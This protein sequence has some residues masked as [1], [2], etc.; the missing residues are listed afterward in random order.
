[1]VAKSYEGQ[2]LPLQ[3]LIGEGNVGLIKAAKRFDGTRG[4]KFISYAVWWIR[5]AIL[6]ALAE[7]ARVVRLPLNRINAIIQIS[8]ATEVL[9]KKLGREPSMPELAKKMEMSES[10]LANL[11]KAALREQSLD[12]PV[13]DESNDNLVDFLISDQ[14]VAPDAMLLQKSLQDD[15]E[16]LLST[17]PSRASDILRRYYGIGGYSP[18]SLE[19]IGEQFQLTRERV[20]QIKENALQNL[21]R[22]SRV[23]TLRHYL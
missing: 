19:M 2:G 6:Q 15:V 5:Q 3:D 11:L 1:M 12:H 17:L 16:A 20:R 14:Y 22:R 4:I 10:E 21:R 7:H 18:H 9:Q 13:G 23:N 8:H